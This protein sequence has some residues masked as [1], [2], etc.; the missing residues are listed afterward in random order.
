ME[1]VDNITHDELV[2]AVS[3]L[4]IAYSD[5][6]QCDPDADASLLIQNVSRAGQHLEE[7][8]DTMKAN[9]INKFS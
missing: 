3:W 5:L 9:T 6:M 2:K 7:L 4:Y 1:T 8:M